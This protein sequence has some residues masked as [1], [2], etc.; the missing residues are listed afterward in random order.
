[1]S[2]RKRANIYAYN[3]LH[4]RYIDTHI[5][6]FTCLY[7]SMHVYENVCIYTCKYITHI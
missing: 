7:L 4:I 1:M 3:D 5:H 2:I 6:M